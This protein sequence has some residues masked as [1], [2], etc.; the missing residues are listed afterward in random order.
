MK[1]LILFLLLVLFTACDKAE[2]DSPLPGCGPAIDINA[3]RANDATDNFA[4]LD[5]NVAGKCLTVTI[6]A[7][8]CGSQAWQLDLVTDGAIGE[9]LPT[10]SA[11]RLLFTDPAAGGIT[12]QAEIQATYEFDLS[13]YLTDEVL[14]TQFSLLDTGLSFSIE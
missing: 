4:L 14:P 13:N 3:D 8:G 10:Q 9:S 6:A 12:C 2:I 1:H 5:A 7:T 11:A